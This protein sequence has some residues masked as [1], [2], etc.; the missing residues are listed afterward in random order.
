VARMT[1]DLP[2]KSGPAILEEIPPATGA[3]NGQILT[4]LEIWVR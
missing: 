2:E 3:L 4:P 1:T